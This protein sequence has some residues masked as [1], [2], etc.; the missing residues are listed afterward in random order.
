MKQPIFLRSLASFTLIEL[1]VVISII[2]ILAGLTVAGMGYANKRAARS[3]AAA[4]IAAM[5][6]AIE[7]YK[8]DNGVYPTS[9]STTSNSTNINAALN[10]PASMDPSNY[11]ESSKFLYGELSGD[12]DFNG[13]ADS[14]SR[15]YFEF[16]ENQLAKS[17]GLINA[18]LDPFGNSYG[19]STVYSNWDGT[20]TRPG[21]N[22]TFDLWS[23]GGYTGTAPEDRANWITNW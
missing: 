17:S 19:Y 6:A 9:N 18:I 20:G 5:S 13:V 3:R 2:V 10:T 11:N 7:N 16:K 21:F 15:T 22:P 23:T 4:E 1:L 12:R 8:A 14:G